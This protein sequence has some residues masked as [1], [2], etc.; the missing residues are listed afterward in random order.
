MRRQSLPP[1]DAVAISAIGRLLVIRSQRLEFGVDAFGRNL[2]INVFDRGFRIG[3]SD[4]CGGRQLFLTF[5]RAALVAL[6]KC[7]IAAVPTGPEIALEGF[8]YPA[9]DEPW[10]PVI[11]RKPAMKET[12]SAGEKRRTK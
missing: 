1:A 5:A 10:V 12:G 2:C 11:A 3:D 7:D 4:R 8:R 6:G 9:L